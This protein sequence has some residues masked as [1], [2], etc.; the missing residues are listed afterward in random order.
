MSE[1]RERRKCPNLSRGERRRERGAAVYRGPSVRPLFGGRRLA[2]ARFRK[3]ERVVV[4]WE[5]R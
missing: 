2:L 3:W 1:K 4:V 5:E